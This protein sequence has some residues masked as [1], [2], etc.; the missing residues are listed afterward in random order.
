M[1]GDLIADPVGIFVEWILWKKN[2]FSNG[3]P[4][5]VDTASEGAQ[6]GWILASI[7]TTRKPLLERRFCLW[8]VLSSGLTMSM[9]ILDP[10][11]MRTAAL[12]TTWFIFVK[13]RVEFATQQGPIFFIRG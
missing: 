2:P 10:L 12:T 6:F 13:M 5:A 1:D 7:T 9:D 3:T 8:V 11:V 4:Q